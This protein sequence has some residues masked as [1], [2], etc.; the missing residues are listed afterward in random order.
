[1]AVLAG[2]SSAGRDG[3]QTVEPVIAQVRLYQYSY[4]SIIICFPCS[5]SQRSEAIR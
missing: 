2:S 1:V 4:R 3:N 5:L